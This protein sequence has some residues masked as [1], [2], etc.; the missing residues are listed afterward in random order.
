MNVDDR[1]HDSVAVRAMARRVQARA[2]ELTHEVTLMEVCGTHTHAIAMAG[3]RHM[4]PTS[5]RLISGPGCPVCVTPVEYIDKAL[6]WCAK[7][8]M[9]LLLDV[10][11][12]M[13]S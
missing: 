6:D 12:A 11:T 1:F 7:Y 8:N 10:H 9:T 2:A 4:L 5:V 13:G 3:L